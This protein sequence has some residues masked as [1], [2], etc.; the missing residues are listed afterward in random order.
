M[1]TSTSIESSDWTLWQ[2][3]DSAF[4]IGGFAHSGG[5]EAAVQLTE[6]TSAETLTAFIDA[7]L[8]QC[9]RWLC[10]YAEA[11]RADTNSFSQHDRLLDVTL[12]NAV[13]NRASRAQ[14]QSLLGTAEA[15]WKDP[16]VTAAREMLRGG[17]PGHWPTCFGLIAATR[18]LSAPAAAEAILF[19]HLR[20][21]ISAAVRLGVIGPL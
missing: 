2:L 6:I 17:A 16:A 19:I 21:L 4:P 5:L 15:V 10:P 7:S 1:S 12:T 3:I 8:H 18:G 13:A 11:V 14:G 9:A 20:G